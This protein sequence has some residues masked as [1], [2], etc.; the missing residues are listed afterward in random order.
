M[1]TFADVARLNVATLKLLTQVLQAPSKGETKKDLSAEVAAAL[2]QFASLPIEAGCSSDAGGGDA[3]EGA[4]GDGGGE[5]APGS[6]GGGGGDAVGESGAAEAPGGDTGGESGAA[7]TPGGDDGRGGGDGD[8]SDPDDGP[9]EDYEDSE[10][11]LFDVSYRL[12][13]FNGRSNNEVSTVE[14]SVDETVLTLKA[15]I[16]ER[17]NIRISDQV[18]LLNDIVLLGSE[19]LIEGGTY[20]M[21]TRISGGGKRAAPGTNAKLGTPKTIRDT[22]TN[23]EFRLN[24]RPGACPTVEAIKVKVSALLRDIDANPTTAFSNNAAQ[25]QRKAVSRLVSEVV[26]G[27]T[28]A[29]RRCQAAVEIVYQAEIE[30]LEEVETQIAKS[31]ELLANLLGL[32][33]LSE[34]GEGAGI[35]W[36]HFSKVLT[37]ILTAP[38]A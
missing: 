34:C 20:T 13:N 29:Y 17:H 1:A 27:N 30:E 33:I 28:D 36:K 9:E 14:V 5:G 2:V 32:A 11:V 18:I 15:I 4:P 22:I 3:G 6:G 31:K 23:L 19:F 10:N 8:D 26:P 37:D 21:R 25:L 24:S 16:R 7:E 38:G 35:S 12:L